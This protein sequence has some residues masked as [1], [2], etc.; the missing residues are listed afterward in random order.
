MRHGKGFDLV[1]KGDLVSRPQEHSEHIHLYRIEVWDEPPEAGG[2]ML[3]IIASAATFAVSIAAF[4]AAVRE[5]PGK[6]IIHMNGRHR[7]SC[8]LAPDPP[9]PL[10]PIATK[11]DGTHTKIFNEPRWTFDSL[12]EWK[13]L[14]IRCK[15]CDRVQP[16]DRWEMA[17]K[18]GKHTV[19]TSLLPKL[20]CECGVRGNSDWLIGK[21]P[22]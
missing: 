2:E 12:Q 1:R 16:V 15:S 17:R 13:T 5:R 3:E 8:Q 18:H 21:M 4:H 20:R 19:I 11:R 6:H 14:A 10:R 22:R 9:V 7:M